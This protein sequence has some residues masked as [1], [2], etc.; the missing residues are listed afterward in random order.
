MTSTHILSPVVSHKATPSCLGCWATPWA[1]V[2]PAVN[3]RL[4]VSLLLP[5]G[6]QRLGDKGRVCHSRQG[7]AGGW[8]QPSICPLFQPAQRLRSLSQ[9]A[10]AGRPGPC[11]QGTAGSSQTKAGAGCLGHGFEGPCCPARLGLRVLVLTGLSCPGRVCPW[12]MLVALLEDSPS[13][14][15]LWCHA[16][17]IGQQ[18]HGRRLCLC[19]KQRFFRTRAAPCLAQHSLY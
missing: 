4:E 1:P 13:P 7:G 18:S 8:P 12:M 15:V 19:S 6:Q 11:P 5:K 17:G 2:G 10:I 14:S 3:Y 9:K 16:L